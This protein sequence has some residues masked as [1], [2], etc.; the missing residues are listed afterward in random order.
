[1]NELFTDVDIS[2]AET[3]LD[4]ITPY[5]T[6]EAFFLSYLFFISRKGFISLYIDREKII[7]HPSQFGL[8]E[9]DLLSASQNLLSSGVIAACPEENNISKIICFENNHFY[10]QRNYILKKKIMAAIAEKENKQEHTFLI[11]ELSPKQ[12]E[13]L[14]H[15]L[16]NHL[17]VI[18]GGPGTGKTK[19]ANLIAHALAK[20]NSYKI[21][22]TAPTAKA[23]FHLKE[24]VGL[25]NSTAMTLHALL[26]L[27]RLKKTSNTGFIDADLIIVDEASMIDIKLMAQFFDAV[28]PHTKIVLLGDENQLFPVAPGEIFS[29]FAKSDHAIYLTEKYRFKNNHLHLIAEAIKN[30]DK[31]KFFALTPSLRP[32]DNIDFQNIIDMHF[33]H[34]YNALPD[35]IDL[36]KKRFD[37][38]ILS[39][40]RSGPLGADELNDKIIK[41]ILSKMPVNK[42]FIAPI[43]ISKNDYDLELY[44]GTM[45]FLNF[46]KQ[47][48][49]S[50]IRETAY[51]CDDD[52]VKRVPA[53]LLKD[54]DYG[55]VLSVHKSQGSEFNETVVILPP[56]SEAFGKKIL[57]TAISRAKEQMKLFAKREDVEKLFS[58][59]QQ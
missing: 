2:F 13:A 23:A 21:L 52:M 16:E 6:S 9:E 44:N 8:Q 57:Y 29:F 42:Y 49:G 30:G 37:F 17:T 55:Y 58:R 48:N 40:L 24:V 31:E 33:L 38:A 10:L 43:I 35:M 20:N 59:S 15:C 1:M 4:K 54:F 26:K 47:D 51:F 50:I 45:G 56:G 25:K 7:P 18:C 36:L 11:E 3:L 46:Y 12:N 41:Y 32:F 14:N 28:L 5:N 34:F 27:H 39:C 22:L 19:T 53:M